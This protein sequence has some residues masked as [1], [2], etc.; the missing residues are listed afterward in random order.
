MLISNAFKFSNNRNEIS[1]LYLWVC[2]LFLQTKFNW[3]TVSPILFPL[4]W[5]GK[6]H[7]LYKAE[8]V[9]Y[10]AFYWKHGLLLGTRVWSNCVMC[11]CRT[12]KKISTIQWVYFSHGSRDWTKALH[13]LC[14]CCVPELHSPAHR[15]GHG[16]RRSKDLGQSGLH[17]K[18][19]AS[20]RD[21]WDFVS[22]E[23]VILC[24]PVWEKYLLNKVEGGSEPGTLSITGRD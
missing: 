6:N 24:L 23:K 8:K 2:Y 12:E 4:C 20:L 17:R 15:G 3:N 18:L 9:C 10:L 14:K 21:T 5:Q 16:W 1:K 7:L 11:M 19:K 22:N 13:G